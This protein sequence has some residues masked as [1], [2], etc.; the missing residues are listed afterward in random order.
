MPLNFLQLHNKRKL[1]LQILKLAQQTYHFKWPVALQR[2]VASDTHVY[3]NVKDFILIFKEKKKNCMIDP[4]QH[5][6]NSIQNFPLLPSL[7]DS[8]ICLE[9]RGRDNESL[10]SPLVSIYA[11][12]LFIPVIH[13]ILGAPPRLSSP[14]PDL[15]AWHF[16]ND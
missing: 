10:R 6:S 14:L 4:R 2:N 11:I 12:R 5:K 16:P 13:Y 7:T 9:V 8:L 15:T 1:R 3:E